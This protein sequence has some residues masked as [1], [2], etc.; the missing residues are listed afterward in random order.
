[1]QESEI[2]VFQELEKFNNNR[3]VEIEEVIDKIDV[4][5]LNTE[6]KKF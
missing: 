3:I 6:E 1:L 4:D 5:N 2:I